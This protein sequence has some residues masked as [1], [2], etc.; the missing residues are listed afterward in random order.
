MSMRYSAVAPGF[1]ASFGGAGLAHGSRFEL[2]DDHR[3]L[4]AP[5]VPARG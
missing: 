2:V 3:G 4:V 5:M 1:P